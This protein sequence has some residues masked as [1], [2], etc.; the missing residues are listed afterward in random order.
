MGGGPRALEFGA[1]RKQ[2]LQRL[3]EAAVQVSCRL[4]RA[5]GVGVLG[6]V[7][8]GRPV[9]VGINHSLAQFPREGI[10]QMDSLPVFLEKCGDRAIFSLSLGYKC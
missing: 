8:L 5:T 9:C 3:I 2:T 6:F 10:L 1:L 4:Q 7:S